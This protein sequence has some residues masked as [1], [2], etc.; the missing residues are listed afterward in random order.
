LERMQW[1]R[2][3]KVISFCKTPGPSIWPLRCLYGTADN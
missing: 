3:R 2:F 1:M